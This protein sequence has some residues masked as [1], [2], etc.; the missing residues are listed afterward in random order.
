MGM[1]WGMT[2]VAGLKKAL[3]TVGYEKLEADDMYKAY[4][5][6]TGIERNGIQ[7]PCAYS[8][9]SRLGSKVVKMYRVKG[10]K[11]IPISDWRETPNAVGLHDFK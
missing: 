7:G 2:Y 1:V 9:T 5:E 8:P 11:V 4:Q 6:L 3:K 10:G